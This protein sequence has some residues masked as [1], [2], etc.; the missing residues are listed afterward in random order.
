MT[1]SPLKL[2][3]LL[4]LSLTLGALLTQALSSPAHELHAKGQR[5]PQRCTA[6]QVPT[7]TNLPISVQGQSFQAGSLPNAQLQALIS[8]VTLPEGF[9]AVGGGAG[10]VI[11]C[12]F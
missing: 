12:S 4:T 6:I 10:V 8:T 11:A 9:R 1:L 7:S 5:A 2:T 3:F